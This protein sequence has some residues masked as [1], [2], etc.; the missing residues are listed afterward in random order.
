MKLRQFYNACN[1][2]TGFN[3]IVTLLIILIGFIMG[4]QLVK[5]T[6]TNL[7][8][9]DALVTLFVLLVFAFFLKVTICWIKLYRQ[10]EEELRGSGIISI[11]TGLSDYPSDK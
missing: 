6:P 3:I 7:D 11:Q 1:I 5:V 4:I 10:D 2:C 9:Y 8:L